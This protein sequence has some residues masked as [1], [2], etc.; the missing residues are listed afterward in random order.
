M[1]GLA[2]GRVFKFFSAWT[3]QQYFI[4]HRDFLK[5]YSPENQHSP[6]KNDDWKTILFLFRY[7]FRGELLNFRGVFLVVGRG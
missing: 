4:I 3:K 6:F 7:I 5:S 2:F 1:E